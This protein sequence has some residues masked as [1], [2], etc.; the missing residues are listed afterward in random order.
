V[1]DPGDG[2]DPDVLS[3]PLDHENVSA[4]HGRGVYLIRHLVDEV[5]YTNGAREIRMKES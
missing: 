3:N 5:Q 2:F 1:S 4:D